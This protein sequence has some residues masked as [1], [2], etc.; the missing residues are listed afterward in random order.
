MRN[1]KTPINNARTRSAVLLGS[2]LTAGL[3]PSGPADAAGLAGHHLF[4]G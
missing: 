4:L 3:L 2:L 1:K